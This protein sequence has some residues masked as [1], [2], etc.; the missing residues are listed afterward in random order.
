MSIK[1]N[2]YI[3]K[4]LFSLLPKLADDPGFEISSP[5]NSC[6]NCISW[7]VLRDNIITWPFRDVDLDGVY[8]PEE[9]EREESLDAFKKL[10]SKSGFVEETK[11]A[12]YEDGFL[13]IAIFTVP[14]D[15]GSK[16]DRKV[17]HAVRQRISDG[18]WWSK[19]GKSFDIFHSIVQS[20]ECDVYGEVSLILKKKFK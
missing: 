15:P 20:V 5:Q 19:L 6:Y 2:L 3:C 9:I 13:K 16:F 10:F 18:L 17:T 12:E 8:W 11:N 7:S 4:E 1:N 14:S